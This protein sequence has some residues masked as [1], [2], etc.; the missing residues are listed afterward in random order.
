MTDV[1]SI[2][3]ANCIREF[4][5]DTSSSVL[6]CGGG[7]FDKSILMHGGFTNVTIS[8]LDTRM[9]ASSYAP[10]QWKF[11][12]A[13]SLSFE[14]N[15]FDYVVIHAAI[16][17]ASSPH[18]VVTEMYRVAKKGVLAIE[19]RDSF[20]MRFFENLNLTQVYEHSA[21]Y[22]NDGKYG[23]VNNSNVPNYVYRWTEREIEKTIKTYAPHARHKFSYRY[24]TSFP[25][26]A[27]VNKNGIVLYVL[28]KA[29]QPF[30]WA[31]TRLFKKQQNLFAFFVKKPSLPGDLYDWLKLDENQ[32]ITFDMAWAESKFKKE[33]R[34]SKDRAGTGSN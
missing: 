19:S 27:Q 6:V 11:E 17:H 9:N 31:L 20:T 18:K 33:N 23:G 22:Y 14:D 32:N 10:Y 26:S 12:N 7:E 28:L 16:H 8:N 2:F 24:A 29:A 3:Y 21:V 15:S 30:F 34:L 5:Q 4:L 25:V 1:R 13:E